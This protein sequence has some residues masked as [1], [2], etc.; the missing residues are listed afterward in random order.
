MIIKD[1]MAI[2]LSLLFYFFF[3]FSTFFLFL[4]FF[5]FFSAHILFFTF[6]SN[7]SLTTGK[8]EFSKRLPHTSLCLDERMTLTLTSSTTV[9]EGIWDK[10]DN[11]IGASE[12]FGFF[13]V[14]LGG[15]HSFKS[16]SG[17]DTVCY[18][19][20]WFVLNRTKRKFSAWRDMKYIQFPVIMNMCLYYYLI[21]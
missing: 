5:F 14:F 19:F 2:P 20:D 8:E 16:L 9:A 17:R 1:K 6:T 11:N 15:N 18:S 7:F 21:N 13:F 3:S 4:L 12:S 10:A